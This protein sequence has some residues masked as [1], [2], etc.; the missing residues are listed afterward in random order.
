MR[1][2]VPGLLLAVLLTLGGPL[3]TAA[4]QKPS[5]VV[6]RFRGHGGGVVRGLVVEAV[7]GT[8]DLTPRA[9]VMSEARRRG[10]NPA[11]KAG[12]RELARAMDLRV[13]VVGRVR[14]RG[15]RARIRIRVYGPDGSKV[16]SAKADPPLGRQSRRALQRVARSTVEKGLSR[17]EAQ[18]EGDK[19]GASSTDAPGAPEDEKPSS[20][21]DAAAASEPV[22]EDR[23]GAASE[24][25]SDAA[26]WVSVRAGI[27]LGAR[28]AEVQLEN[29]STRIYE[30]STYPELVLAMTVRPFA[31]HGVALR[32]LRLQALGAL[33]VGLD[34]SAQSSASDVETTVYRARVDALYTYPVAEW[35]E[36]GG[37]VG[38]GYEAFVLGDN[39]V[40]P[41]SRYPSV[42]AG[43]IG[44]IPILDPELELRLDAGFRHAF[45]AGGLDDAFG[46]DAA[47][48]GFDAGW[49]LR[50]RLPVG[51]EYGV[52]VAY[53]RMQLDFA[54]DAQDAEGKDGHDQSVSAMVLLGWGF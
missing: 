40:L 33:E 30:W 52:R 46:A 13:F 12:R 11:T 24:T 51:F 10:A 19:S 7:Q 44:T 50:G 47:A 27:A 54:G 48:L 38:F 4:A 2:V 23:P 22:A 42:R 49:A 9:K 26:P 3:P 31:T 18:P 45:G 34:S 17:I 39:P 15:R 20:A 35:L 29:G 53:R 21:P 16:A 25:P 6:L 37:R 32:G 36:L 5:G 8:L 1:V 28:Q 43:L 14:G 41:T